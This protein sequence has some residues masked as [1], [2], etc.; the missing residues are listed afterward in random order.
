MGLPDSFIAS[1]EAQPSAITGG[2]G[3]RWLARQQTG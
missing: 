3:S 1:E 2:A